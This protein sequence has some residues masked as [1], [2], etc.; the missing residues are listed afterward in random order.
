MDGREGYVLYLQ[1]LG[2]FRQNIR[3]VKNPR[4]KGEIVGSRQSEDKENGN[5]SHYVANTINRNMS[6]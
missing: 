6:F 1:H 5:V 2:R 3:K 4:R